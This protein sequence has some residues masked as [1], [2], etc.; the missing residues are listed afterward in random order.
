MRTYFTE[1]I[2]RTQDVGMEYFSVI[3]YGGAKMGNAAFDGGGA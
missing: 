3:E 2:L 1:Y